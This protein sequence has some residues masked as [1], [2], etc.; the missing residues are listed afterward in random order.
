MITR[1]IKFKLKPESKEDFDTL[2]RQFKDE[3][4]SFPGVHHLDIL[5]EK[6]NPLSIFIIMIF[7]TEER[8][9]S[10]RL[11]DLNRVIKHRLK[12]LIEGDFV[13]WMFESIDEN[14]DGN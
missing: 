7:I 14:K 13:V 9:E 8:L 12:L 5:S 10:F 2:V 1:I 11:S 4:L 6:S 3:L